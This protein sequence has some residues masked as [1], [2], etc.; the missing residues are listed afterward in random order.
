MPEFQIGR[1][2]KWAR[3]A[4]FENRWLR[5]ILLEDGETVHNIYADL[6]ASGK[7][8][9]LKIPAR[10]LKKCNF[11]TASSARCRARA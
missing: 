2:R 11:R 5:V 6:D 4:S 3:I 9:A 10:R 8:V 7:V 1:I